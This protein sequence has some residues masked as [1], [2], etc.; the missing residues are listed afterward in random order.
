MSSLISE[1]SRN[2]P[3]DARVI[4]RIRLWNSCS[5]SCCNIASRSSRIFSIAAMVII[6]SLAGILEVCSVGSQ[7]HH[8]TTDVCVKMNQ[9]KACSSSPSGCREADSYSERLGRKAFTIRLFSSSGNVVDRPNILTIEA[10]ESCIAQQQ[11]TI[12]SGIA[13]P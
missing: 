1:N 5:S 10:V 6:A 3:D 12:R 11:G 4:Y 8:M 7:G 2:P 9:K 13:E